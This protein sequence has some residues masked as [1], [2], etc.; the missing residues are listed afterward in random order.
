[1]YD[2]LTTVIFVKDSPPPESGIRKIYESTI[3]LLFL[4][5]SKDRQIKGMFHIERWIAWLCDAFFYHLN[6]IVKYM[7]VQMLSADIYVICREIEQVSYYIN[8]FV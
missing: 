3:Q 6:L 2:K 4:K 5:V 1:M 7:Y 8:Y